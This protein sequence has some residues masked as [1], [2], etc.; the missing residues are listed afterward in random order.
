M[1]F[2]VDDKV[3]DYSVA[4]DSK[5]WH[6]VGGLAIDPVA[7]DSEFRVVGGV[8]DLDPVEGDLGFRADGGDWGID[9]A[10]N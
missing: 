9:Y 10:T 1:K 5:F 6:D 7:D 3:F 2:Q 8:W 4:N